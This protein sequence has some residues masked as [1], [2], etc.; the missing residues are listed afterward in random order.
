MW[1]GF[2]QLSSGNILPL[3]QCLGTK[4]ADSPH[5]ALGEDNGDSHLARLDNRSSTHC[6]LMTTLLMAVA[7]V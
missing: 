3:S 2:A 6:Q 7:V 1:M 4:G 5:V